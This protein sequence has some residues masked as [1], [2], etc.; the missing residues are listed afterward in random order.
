MTSADVAVYSAVRKA[1]MQAT[2][3]GSR[4]QAASPSLP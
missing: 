1:S 4:G 2:I 3:N